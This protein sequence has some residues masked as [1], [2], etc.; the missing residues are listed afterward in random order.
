MSDLSD[1][2]S[3]IDAWADMW[4]EMQDKQVHP[5]LE[6]PKQSDFA[7]KILGDDPQDTYYDS[8]DANELFQ[9]SEEATQN[10]VRMDTIGPDNKHP[11][12]AWV[13][14]DFLSEI[15]DLKDR[16]FKLENDMAR[17]GQGITFSENPVATG[18]DDLMK[19]IESRRSEIEDVSSKL[20]LKDDPTPFVIK[21]S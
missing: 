15:E 6:K 19:K 21:K 8:L 7:N 17:M 13:K 9:E 11:T 18:K 2:R 16:L 1:Y 10:P 5:A 20:G 4:D 3:E 14:E 12:A